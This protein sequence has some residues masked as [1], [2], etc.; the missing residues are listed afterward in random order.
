MLRR[1]S[2]VVI[3]AL[4][5]SPGWAASGSALQLNSGAIAGSAAQLNNNGYAGTYITLAEPGD[6]TVNVNAAGTS[7]GGVDPR[8]NI[9]IADT[10]TGFDVS[11]GGWHILQ[12]RLPVASRRQVF[13]PH[14]VQQRRRHRPRAD[15][16][17]PRRRGS[18]DRHVDQRHGAAGQCAGGGGHLHREFSQRRQPRSD[19]SASRRERKSA[20]S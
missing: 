2:I 13:R 1:L 8:M 14:R 5:A 18:D 7:F 15:D 12:P 4:V 3:C 11:S 16:Q 9:V 20:S 6:V 17:Q 19:S 10:K